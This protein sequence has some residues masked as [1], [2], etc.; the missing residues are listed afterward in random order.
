[1]FPHL[2]LTLDRFDSG[3][4]FQ[5][6]AESR[7]YNYRQFFADNSKKKCVLHCAEKGYKFAGMANKND[8]FC[9]H[10]APPSKWL[11]S[12]TDC[13]LS[14]PSDD[15][16]KS[17][18]HKCGG[19]SAINIHSTGVGTNQ[20]GEVCHKQWSGTCDKKNLVMKILRDQIRM[21]L[22]ILLKKNCQ[23]KFNFL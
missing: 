12:Q 4:C 13:D 8:C 21:N 10:Y 2:N 6:S 17:D 7:V 3:N 9:G 20:A 15:I 11:R 1:M 18:I 22:V 16:H 14:C 19:V 5:N 23:L